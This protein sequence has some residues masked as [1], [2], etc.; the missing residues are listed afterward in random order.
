MRTIAI[1]NQK[2]GCGKTTTA[3]N[4]SSVFA[5][6]GLRTLLVDLDPQAHCAA[7][8]AVPEAKIDKHI[9]DAMLAT[10]KPISPDRYVWRIGRRLDLAPSQTK[11]AALEATRG[12]LAD[13]EDRERRLVGVLADLN[14][15]VP[16]G[17][18][19]CVIDCPPSIGLLTYNALAAAREIVI[20]VET[21]FFSLQG[22]SKQVRTIRSVG[23]K[24]GLR[25]RVRLLPTIHDPA[26][27]LARDLL[28]EL[29]EQ[30]SDRVIPRVI[31]RDER[32]KLAASYGVPVCEHAPDSDAAEDYESLAEWLMEHAKLEMADLDEMDGLPEIGVADGPLGSRWTTAREQAAVEE[33]RPAGRPEPRP[34]AR[35]IDRPMPAETAASRV[36]DIR[37][38]AN[39]LMRGADESLASTRI[40]P[41]PM[42]PPATPWND[43]D[44]PTEDPSAQI[45]GV[46]PDSSV[47][48]GN[49]TATFGVHA[50]GNRVRFVQPIEAGHRL[51]VAGSFN[52]WSPTSLPM[53]RNDA[54]GVHEITVE[55]LPGE[56][57]YRLVTDGV[58]RS[59]PYNDNRMTNDHGEAFSIVVVQ[60]MQHA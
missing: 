58:W 53:R 36:D 33:P 59:D 28:A 11:L 50:S 29:N 37:R 24:I 9:G 55:L 34:M 13:L 17:Y 52:G 27:P 12:G 8:L 26:S 3:I 21:S 6:R 14:E 22:A 60:A 18:D 1:I 39:L 43:D 51:A 41:A 15:R 57:R 48:S 40:E 44:E 47:P 5:G 42:Q 49:G 2:G 16:G 10:D 45:N 54:L 4:L 35:P 20:P 25:H 30:F 7:G 31:R 56:H 23:R 19:V 38:R 46:T 32:V